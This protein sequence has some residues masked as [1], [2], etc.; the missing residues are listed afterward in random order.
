[1]LCETQ[2]SIPGSAR[3]EEERQRQRDRKWIFYSN[4][5]IHLLRG[6]AFVSCKSK[7]DLAIAYLASFDLWLSGRILFCLGIRLLLGVR[8]WDARVSWRNE[9]Q[10]CRNCG[11][12]NGDQKVFL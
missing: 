8:G 7:Q 11:S 4:P 1:M 3:K 6:K 5:E 2:C 10:G 12:P 9:V